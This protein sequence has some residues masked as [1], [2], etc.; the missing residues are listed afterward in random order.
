MA[1]VRSV[2]LKTIKDLYLN[3]FALFSDFWGEC[4]FY[5]KIYV[6][7]ILSQFYFSLSPQ[8]HTDERLMHL[9]LFPLLNSQEALVWFIFGSPF[10]HYFCLLL[11]Q[12]FSKMTSVSFV[13]FVSGSFGVGFVCC[14]TPGQHV[15]RKE[16]DRKPDWHTT[17]VHWK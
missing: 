12:T 4:I 13:C 14:K 7:L 10:L 5:T 8:E 16:E 9:S 3:L 1:V 2:Y 17:F 15:V 11:S 6:V